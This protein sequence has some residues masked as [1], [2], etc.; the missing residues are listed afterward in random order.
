[1]NHDEPSTT[2]ESLMGLFQSG[3]EDAFRTLFER[4]TV[5]LINFAYRFLSSRSEAEDV[6]QEVF[7]RIYRNKERFDT[8]RPFRGWIF[9]IAARLASNHASKRK[10]HAETALDRNPSA[11]DAPSLAETLADSAALTPEQEELRKELAG[12][13]QKA[14]AD[15]P[16]PQRTAVLLS[17]FEGMSYDEIAGT[18]GTTVSAIKSLLFR[19]RQ[20]LV[21]D[22]APHYESE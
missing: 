19:A 3:D 9:T 11:E 1:M 18:M 16:S 4:Y 5:P 13:V 2:D 10:T 20:T 12:K 7:L 6:A 15:L 22:L 8:G 21:K 14:L 17:R